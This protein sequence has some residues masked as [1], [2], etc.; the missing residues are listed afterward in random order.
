MGPVALTTP[1]SETKSVTRSET[2]SGIKVREVVRERGVRD[3]VRKRVRDGVR[4]RVRD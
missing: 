1:G 3:R 2:G 4:S